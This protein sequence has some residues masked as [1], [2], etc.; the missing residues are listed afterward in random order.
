MYI[1]VIIITYIS[2]HFG[3]DLETLIHGQS[4]SLRMSAVEKLMTSM[5]LLLF[6]KKGSSIYTIN[7]L[8]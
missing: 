3:F 4:F 1:I 7:L 8:D 2:R 6:L 5:T